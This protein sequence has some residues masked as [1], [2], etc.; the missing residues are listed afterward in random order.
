M[1]WHFRCD[2]LIHRNGEEIDVH[3]VATNDGA[4][5]ITRKDDVLVAI[6]RYV[7]QVRSACLHKRDL[8][9]AVGNLNGNRRGQARAVDNCGN[10][11]CTAK[12]TNFSAR[13][14]AG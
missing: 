10:Q 7:D 13:Y 4:L 3:D 8:K 2:G 9:G 11:P 5:H 12:L 6:Y 14:G 1:N